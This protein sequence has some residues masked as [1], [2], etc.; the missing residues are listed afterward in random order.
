MCGIWALISSKPSLHA[1]AHTLFQAL[2]HR[3]PDSH[4]FHQYA[5]VS[6]G[7]HRLAIMDPSAASNQP[8]ICQEYNGHTLMLMCNG[9]IYNYRELMAGNSDCA[10]ILHQYRKSLREPHSAWRFAESMRR[11]RGEF[12]FVLLEFSQHMR[13]IRVV[14]GRDAI[15]VRP[16]YLG[17][18]GTSDM[19][20]SSE[21]KG[22]QGVGVGGVPGG[23][24]EFP[25]G[26]VWFI[27]RDELGGWKMAL[28]HGFNDVLTARPSVDATDEERLAAVRMSVI[29]SVRRRLSADRPMAFL[30]SGGV[31]SSLV[32]ALS[33][34][35]LGRPIRTF[36]CGM[37]G[38]TDLAYARKVADWIGSEHTEVHFT[39][40]EGLAAIRDVV[41]TVESWDVT[42]VR[43]SVGQYLVSRWIGTK[44]DAR[45][46]LVGEGPDEVCSS[47]LFNW[48]AP[49]GV[50]LDR[51]ARDY[52]RGI[53]CYD[54]K[55]ADRCVARWGLEARVPLLDPEFIEAYWAIPGAERMPAARGMEKWWLRRA[56]EE[57]GTEDLKALLPAEVLW[58]KK[59]AFSDGV[60]GERSWF[61][62]I[63]EWV[64]PQVTDEEMAGAAVRW[65]FATP[66]TKE[67]YFYRRLFEEFY[68]GAAE[69]VPGFWQPRWV[70]SGGYVD[71]SARVL[72]VYA[73]AEE[74]AEVVA[75]IG[76]RCTSAEKGAAECADSSE[77]AEDAEAV[78]D[79]KAADAVEDEKAVSTVKAVDA[80]QSVQS[81]SLAY[82]NPEVVVRL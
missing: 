59:E 1:R 15:G 31:D 65:P 68:P 26:N 39:A 22:V 54:V 51:S 70:N 64:E 33:A 16:L 5:D 3:G 11:V 18:E 44:T 42:T 2:A 67:A 36:C 62:I 49:D 50:A 58:R 35:I 23:V 30:L 20:F 19:V 4:I 66:P 76:E 28:Q 32:A 55:R 82:S 61:Q 6:L 7:F 60:S 9:E 46:L 80:V 37:A 73:K 38:G 63:Q 13:L 43:A 47:Y 12:A 78:E 27:E 40:E 25:P 17:G 56:F 48:Y 24:R 69:I 8:F 21:V 79:E 72:G 77:D 34:R 45:V 71:P 75:A 74:V 52:V 10:A 53:H 41:R 29:R 14:A 57:A 81:P